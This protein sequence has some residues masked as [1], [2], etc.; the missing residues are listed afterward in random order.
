[1]FLYRFL[2]QDSLSNG[3]PSEPRLRFRG[4]RNIHCRISLSCPSQSEAYCSNLMLDQYY[5]NSVIIPFSLKVLHGA[6]TWGCQ[7]I[8]MN[9]FPHI[10]LAYFLVFLIDHPMYM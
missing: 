1:M 6:A 8:A 5:I 10:K 9:D 4:S 3:M 7:K 2:V